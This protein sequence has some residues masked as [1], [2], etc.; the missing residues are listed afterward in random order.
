MVRCLGLDILRP[1]TNSPLRAAQSLYI[2]SPNPIR[3]DG[4]R[5]PYH[6]VSVTCGVSWAGTDHSKLA[7]EGSRR[8]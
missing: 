6:M 8:V 3:L 7:Q 1:H 4:R 2:S 5:A